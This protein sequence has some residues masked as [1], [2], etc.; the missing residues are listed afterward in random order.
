M[1]SARAKPGRGQQGE[2]SGSPGARGWSSLGRQEGP[3][4]RG[5]GAEPVRG[6][7]RSDGGVPTGLVLSVVG[8]T[9][10][11]LSKTLSATLM[12]VP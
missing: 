2:L 7:D 10:H 4:A 8:A 3:Q 9:G 1:V 11:F 12:A 6:Q 5:V